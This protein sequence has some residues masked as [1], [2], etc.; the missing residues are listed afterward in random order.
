MS[1][2]DR[3]V[4]GKPPATAEEADQISVRQLAA[5]RADLSQPRQVVHFLEF[6]SE[7]SAREALAALE[8]GG[9]EATLTEPDD[10]TLHWTVRA[11][12]HRVVDASTVAAFRAWFEGIARE[13][14]GDYDGWEAAREP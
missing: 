3:R 5:L 1:F 4:R 14:G 12:A 6:G 2:I 13:Y 10:D 8:R 7:P 11:E 9:Y